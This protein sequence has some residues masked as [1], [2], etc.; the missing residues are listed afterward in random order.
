MPA[1]L[2]RL[3]WIGREGW[4]FLRRPRLFGERFRADGLRYLRPIE[5]LGWV[6]GLLLVTT[7]LI[8]LGR[9][10]TSIFTGS[11]AEVEVDSSPSIT[12]IAVGLYRDKTGW[13]P[14]PPGLAVLFPDAESRGAST[15]QRCVFHLGC[16]QIT[17]DGVAPTTVAQKE[18]LLLLL[19]LLATLGLTSFHPPARLLG[20]TGDAW[21][22][23]GLGILLVS[24][25]TA[26][27]GPVALAQLYLHGR[28]PA[29]TLIIALLA[30]IA[31]V[32]L[33]IAVCLALGGYHRLSRRRT[34]LAAAGAGLTSQILI[35]VIVP[36]ALLVI[37]RFA[38]VWD[39][40]L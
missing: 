26:L 13:H 18:V 19:L 35:P 4:T 28:Q 17:L 31:M 36:P 27:L 5:V 22:G 25:G 12:A 37:L 38:N 7:L 16:T 3:G 32:W 23:A 10:D 39:A 6:L 1:W 8:H 30:S 2:V 24:Y 29:V 15:P 9:G 11:D 34:L 21:R 33:M 14:V 40:L 20:G